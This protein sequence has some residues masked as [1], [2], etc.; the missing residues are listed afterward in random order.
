MSFFLTLPSNSSMAHFPDNNPSHFITKLPETIELTG[1]Y[2]V[3]LAEIQVPKNFMNVKEGDLYMHLQ[4]GVA[5]KAIT[6]PAGLYNDESKLIGDLKKEMVSFAKMIGFDAST[7]QLPVMLDYDSTSKK[8][9]L[10]L[11]AG[12]P[13]EVILTISQKLAETLKFVSTIMVSGVTEII[14]ST[15]PV[16]VIE[17]GSDITNAYVYCDLIQARPVGDTMAPLLRCMPLAQKDKKAELVSTVFTKPYYFPL[18]RNNFNT[19]ELLIT[20][21]DGQRVPF[22]TGTSIITLHFRRATAY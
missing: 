10:N 1:D 18:S 6:L 4:N 13:R 17:L 3:G 19:L 12:P 14:E 9:S 16:D 8:A 11:K 7:D 20:L 2:E 5:K 15:A 22:V 21:G